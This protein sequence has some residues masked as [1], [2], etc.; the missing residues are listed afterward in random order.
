[1]AGWPWFWSAGVFIIARSVARPLSLITTAIRQV[2][3]GAEGVQVPHTERQDEIGALARAIGV[4]QEAMDRNRNLNSQVLLDSKAREERSRQIEVSVEAFRGAIG[5]VLGAVNDNAT[6]MRDTAKSISSVASNATGRANAAARATEQASA[7]FSRLPARP[8]SCP[9]RSRRSAD[10]YANR[11]RLSNR[12]ASAPKNRSP[13]SKVSPRLLNA[14]TACST[15]FR[16][17]PNRPTFW[18]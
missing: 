9:P 18:R 5:S 15:S 3:E 8:N 10:K 14:S 6:A 7:T 12:P 17:L 4:F 16:R 11:R 13:K 1:M 2:A